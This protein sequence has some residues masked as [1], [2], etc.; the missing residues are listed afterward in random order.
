MFRGGKACNRWGRIRG[1]QMQRLQ[2]RPTPAGIGSHPVKSGRFV[3]I[4]AQKRRREKMEATP[5]F[6][7]TLPQGRPPAGEPPNGQLGTSK[8]SWLA[9]I[10]Q[11]PEEAGDEKRTQR[12]G[13]QQVGPGRAALVRGRRPQAPSAPRIRE[14]PQPALPPRGRGGTKP[15]LLPWGREGR[16]DRDARLPQGPPPPHTGGF[17]SGRGGHRTFI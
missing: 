14:G 5:I 8:S 1:R 7:K 2:R 9:P 16:P 6:I 12:W 4:A 15:G 10:S 13:R 17:P 11:T 3:P